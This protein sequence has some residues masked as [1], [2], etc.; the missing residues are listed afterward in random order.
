MDVPMINP[1]P[2]GDGM[3]VDNDQD[4]VIIMQKINKL[5]V[6]LKEALREAKAKKHLDSVKAEAC[7]SDTLH[8][9]M[10]NLMNI[11][12]SAESHSG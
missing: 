9:L 12:D 6:S 2:E 8:V 11:C 3:M 1:G 7:K 4:I 10:A 5:L